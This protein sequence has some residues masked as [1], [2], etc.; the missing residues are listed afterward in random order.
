MLASLARRA[1]RPALS[2]A[3]LRSLHATSAAQAAV[4]RQPA[5]AFVCGAV[6]P[7]GT[8]GKVSLSDYKGK[9]LVLFTYP[10]DFTFVW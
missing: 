10:L 2:T 7:D 6:M 8:F 5:P 9:Y 3:S 1:A 4:V